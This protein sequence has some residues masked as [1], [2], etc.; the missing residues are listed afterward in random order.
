MGNRLQ[1]GGLAL[2][3]D[4]SIQKTNI[5]LVVIIIECL[6]DKYGDGSIWWYVEHPLLKNNVGEVVGDGFFPSKKL[7][8]LGDQK[9]V[10][11]FELEKEIENV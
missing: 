8:P 10:E 6:G 1:V 4:S 2:T 5:G 3:L 9:G 7:M 11:M